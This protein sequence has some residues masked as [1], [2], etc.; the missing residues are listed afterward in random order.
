MEK[1]GDA[2]FI[3]CGLGESVHTGLASFSRDSF[4]SSFL[5][6]LPYVVRAAQHTHAPGPGETIRGMI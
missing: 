2:D 3:F 5:C 1:A 6:Q 4:P